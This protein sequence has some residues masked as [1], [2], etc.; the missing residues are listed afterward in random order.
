MAFQDSELSRE[1]VVKRQGRQEKGMP[2]RKV[3]QQKEMS[4]E[5]RVK[6][7]RHQERESGITS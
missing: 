1:R 6:R 5:N 3:R 2:K 4:S 7:Q